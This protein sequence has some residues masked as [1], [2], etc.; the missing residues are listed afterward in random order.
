MLEIRIILA[1]DFRATYVL[2]RNPHY[3]GDIRT[4]GVYAVYLGYGLLEQFPDY[5]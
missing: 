4:I 2:C 3:E 1:P 5:A